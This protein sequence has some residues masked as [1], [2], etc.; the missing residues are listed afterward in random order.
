MVG[1]VL[2]GVAVAA[3]AVAAYRM[4]ARRTPVAVSDVSYRR[5]ERSLEVAVRNGG[6][7]PVYVRPS[8]LLMQSVSAPE[9]SLSAEG[10]QYRLTEDPVMMAGRCEEDVRR[11]FSLLAWDEE[12]ALVQPY[13]VVTRTYPL[14]CVDFRIDDPVDVDV[15]Y[16]R[17][18][19]RLSS[20]AVVRRRIVRGIDSSPVEGFVGERALASVLADAYGGDVCDDVEEG[21]IAAAVAA[22]VDELSNSFSDD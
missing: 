6:A 5:G 22:A 20:R 12:P 9:Q 15:A 4:T 14:D 19:H 1:A 21:A 18:P 10:V 11:S 2:G 16:G 3:L 17:Y 13:G 8:L 7:T